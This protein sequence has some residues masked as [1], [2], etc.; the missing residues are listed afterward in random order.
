MKKKSAFHLLPLHRG[1][2]TYSPTTAYDGV[3]HTPHGPIFHGRYLDSWNSVNS[4]AAK[5]LGVGTISP[6]VFRRRIVRYV[7]LLA[8]APSW[9]ASNRAW[10]TAPGVCVCVC[11]CLCVMYTVVYGSSARTSSV[12]TSLEKKRH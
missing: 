6:R 8:L 11:V 10:K 12:R 3:C 5:E 4:A 1:G 9:L 2:T 7:T